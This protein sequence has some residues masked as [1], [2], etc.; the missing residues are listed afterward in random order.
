MVLNDGGLTLIARDYTTVAIT[1]ESEMRDISLLKVLVLIGL[2]R[3]LTITE[4]P[5]LCSGIYAV[6]TI[7]MALAFGSGVL[8]AALVGCVS[9]VLASIYFYLLNR[10]HSGLLY[11]VILVG[12]LAIGLV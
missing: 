11:W 1:M 10:F 7:V 2:L 4:K 8:K 6:V 12:G 9:F 3:I 5:Y